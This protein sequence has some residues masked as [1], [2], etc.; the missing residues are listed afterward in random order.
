M[1]T[2]RAKNVL[3]Y[4]V[5]TILSNVCFFLFTVIDGIFVGQGVGIDGVGAVNLAFPFIMVA[6]AVT[7]LINIGG[8]TIFAICI[9]RGETEQANRIFRQGMG[10]LSIAAA[11]LCA[12]GTLCAG[13]LV[14]LMGASSTF[15]DLA[16]DYLFWYCAFLIPSALQMGL[17]HY[18]RNDGAPGLVSATVVI[19]TVCNIFL[20][21]LFIF[22]LSMGTKGAAIATGLSQTLGLFIMLTHFLLR[23]GVLRFGRFTF[24]PALFRQIVVHGL[25]EGIAQ[26]AGP[27]M[28][29]C[30]N[31]VLAE[32]VGDTG[33]NAFSVIAYVA[34]FSLAV[35]FGT[36]EGMQPLF[37]Q[38]Y[39]A[40]NE[41]D[42]RFYFRVGILINFFGGAF[43]TGLI[44]VFSRPICALFGADAQTLEYTLFAMPRYAWGFVVMSFNVMITSYLYST[45]RSFH[46]SLIS[47]L[48]SVV[49]SSAVILTFPALFGPGVIW[50]TFGIYEAIVLVLAA[51]IWRYSERNG[52]VFHSSAS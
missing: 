1:F 14:T 33:V 13:P 27:V 28:T 25:P 21:W 18:C 49:I 31:L 37:G 35:F 47:F 46:S 48:R 42:L 50:Y 15:H 23:R 52:I 6:G 36:S 38:S 17:Q 44:L 30:M 3:K 43:L 26:L 34:S 29:L 41:A 32:Y 22:P 40:K 16:A 7:M 45:E 8:V 12:V 20:D 5:P 24:N 11:A 4:V 2:P 39:G 19:T 10:M 51:A 9:G